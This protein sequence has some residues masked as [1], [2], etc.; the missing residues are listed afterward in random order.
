MTIYSCHIAVAVALPVEGSYT[1]GVPDA[2]APLATPGKRVLVPFGRRRVTGY[3]LGE[4]VPSGGY[5]VKRILDVLD[6]VPLFPPEM[7]P[8]FK[9]VADYY[10]HPLGEVIQCALP[11]GLNVYDRLTVSAT[12]GGLTVFEAGGRD[13]TPLER[14]VMTRLKSGPCRL[15]DLRERRVPAALVQTLEDRGWLVRE[16]VLQGGVARPRMER[17]AARGDGTPPASLSRARRDIL[18]LLESREEM[19]ISD[20]KAQVP[21]APR[22]VRAMVEQGLVRVYEKQVYRDPFGEPIPPDTPRTLNPEQAGVVAEV[23]A[24]TGKGFCPFLLAGVTGSGKTEVYLHLARKVM[25]KGLPVLVL[26]PE[27]AL[28][29]QMERRFRAR[30][31]EAV[32]VLHSGLSAGERLDQWQRILNREAAVVIGARSAVFAPLDHIGLVIVDEEHDTSYKQ[33]ADLLYNARDIAVVRAKLSDAV[34]IL[35][36]AT[37]SVH[38]CYNVRTGKFR[39]LRIRRRVAS[40]PLPEIT[41][42]DLKKVADT[43]GARRFITPPLHA[44]MTA[45]L[46]RKEQVLLFLN[47]RGFASFP[48]CA[49]CGEALRCVH[50]DITLTYHRLAGVYRCHYCGY[51]RKAPCDCPA[52]GPA[53]IKLLGMGTEKVEAAVKALFPD[54]RVARMDRDT[55]TRKGSVVR[56]LKS[57]RKGA[58]DVLVG[59]QMVAK[60]HDFPN[61]TVVGVICADLSLSFPDFR[62]GER[63]F[64]LLAQVAGRAGRGDAPGRMILQTFTPD[65]FSIVAA[66]RQDYEAFYKVEIG[67]RR[68]LGYPPVSRIIQLRISGVDPEATRETAEAL[69]SVCR[70]LLQQEAVYRKWVTLLGPVEASIQKIAG[71]YRWQ[72]LVKGLRIGPLRRFVRAVSSAAPNLF[73]HPGVRVVIDV[74]PYFLS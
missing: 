26:V 8:F 14:E 40:R 56:I 66:T 27:I 31:G 23:D 41:V 16:A 49:A 4:T 3:V 7:I 30:F 44:A 48:V 19:S 64:Q 33:G 5:A 38:T 18:A 47:R 34:V 51:T 20:I 65:H 46:E 70:E 21:T 54:A 59:T 50:C 12:P 69:G 67:F 60:G 42:V 61:I 53:P 62:A 1:Y 63:T 72:M 73:R 58:V 28:I 52:C 15:K 35:G 22:L 9:W 24:V 43:R 74:D 71:R 2:L 36:S 37:P 13:L 10:M 29:S 45:A 25:E 11:G 6:P 32:A 39:E 57:L 68:A 55:T 17:F